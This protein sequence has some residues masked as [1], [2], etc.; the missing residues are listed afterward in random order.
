MARLRRSDCAKAGIARRRHG[1][2]VRYL[3]VSGAPVR[4]VDTLA[5]IEALAIPPA[6]RDVWICLDPLGHLQA[7]GV[8]AAGRKQY[9][10][11][12]QW[13]TRRDTQKFEAMLAF[14]RSLPHLRRQVRRDLAQSPDPLSRRQVLAA[15]VRLLDLGSFRVGSDDYAE[16]NESY[17]LTTLTRSH[18]SVGQTGMIF[19]YPAK[20]GVRR[21]QLIQDPELVG[22]LTPLRR[23]RSGERL[24]AFRDGRRWTDVHA[25]DVNAYLK[26]HAA[27]SVSAKDFRTWNATVL[28]AVSVASHPVVGSPSSRERVIREAIA[29][30]ADHLGNTPAVSRASYVDPRV[31]DRYRAGTDIRAVLE[32]NGPRTDPADRRARHRIEAAVLELLS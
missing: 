13:R 25:E 26:E 18:L 21:V 7:T 10:Y 19:D 3:D 12:D 6:W 32:Q 16:Q 8:D 11:H 29:T 2:G 14:G 20:S 27:P 23:R 31:L 28:A 17:G 15:A 24:L 5:R 1:R 22:I 4:D 9:R 30:V